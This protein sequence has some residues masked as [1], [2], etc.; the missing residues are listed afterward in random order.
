MALLALGIFQELEKTGKIKKFTHDDHNSPESV[1]R[2]S[3]LTSLRFPDIC[4]P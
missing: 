2:I 3:F 4:T 1:S